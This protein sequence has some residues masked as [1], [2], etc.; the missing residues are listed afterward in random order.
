MAGEPT[1]FRFTEEEKAL[2]DALVQQT[3]LARGDVVQLALRVL[4][5]AWGM[6]HPAAVQALPDEEAKVVKR[7]D[8]RKRKQK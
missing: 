8:G 3:G 5:K 6:V 1:S 4:T 2:L 7:P